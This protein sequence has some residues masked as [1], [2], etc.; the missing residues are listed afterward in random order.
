MEFQD[1]LLYG[2]DICSAKQQVKLPEFL[3]KLKDEKKISEEAFRK[4]IR[5]NVIKL[6]GL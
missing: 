3:V 4:I 2:T 1:R 5:G 6:L